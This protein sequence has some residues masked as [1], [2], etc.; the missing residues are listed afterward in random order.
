MWVNG[1]LATLTKN[2]S[3]SVP[4]VLT[5]SDHY[6]MIHYC[7]LS[8]RPLWVLPLQATSACLPSQHNDVV[9]SLV[10]YNFIFGGGGGGGGEYKGKS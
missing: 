3:V 4:L 5:A 6:P 1:A 8:T 7:L 9:L 2:V 10:A